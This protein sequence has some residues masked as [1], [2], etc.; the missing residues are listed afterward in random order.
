[1]V[2]VVVRQGDWTAKTVA[3]NSQGKADKRLYAAKVV[4]KWSK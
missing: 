1:M 4:T 3:K 2:I